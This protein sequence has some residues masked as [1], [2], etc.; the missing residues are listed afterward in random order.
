MKILWQ[1]LFPYE[2]SVCDRIVNLS[3]RR[4]AWNVF[5]SFKWQLHPWCMK[6]GKKIRDDGEFAPTAARNSICLIA[7]NTV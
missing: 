7:Q 4:S 6:C 1:L 3:E 2:M 5:R